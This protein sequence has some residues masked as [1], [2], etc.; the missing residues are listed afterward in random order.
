MNR[1]YR[2]NIRAGTT[3]GTYFWINFVNVAGGDRFHWTFIN[4][5]TTCGTIF[6]NLVSHFE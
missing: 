1:F 4:T 5:G 2:A 6:R 3:I